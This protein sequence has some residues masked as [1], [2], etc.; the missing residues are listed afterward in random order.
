MKNKRTVAVGSD[1]I[2]ATMQLPIHGIVIDNPCGGWLYIV[3]ANDF[4]PPYTLQWSRDLEYAASAITIRYG[5]APAGQVSTQQGDPYT[6]TMDSEFVGNSPGSAQQFIDK[7]TGTLTAN[8]AGTIGV[9]AFPAVTILVGVTNKRIRMKTATV[10]LDQSQTAGLSYD[11]G[12]S[13]LLSDAL[14][15]GGNVQIPMYLSGHDHPIDHFI[16]DVD[17]P[18]SSGINLSG[19]SEYRNTDIICSVTYQLI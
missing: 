15:G 10:M 17:F 9:L 13:M 11:A 12:V 1:L 16:G 7:F 4:C 19:T 8:F 5:Q 18:V 3:E 2:S 6:L 14:S